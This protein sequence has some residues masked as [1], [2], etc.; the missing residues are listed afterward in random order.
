MKTMKY[1]LGVL[2][3]LAGVSAQAQGKFQP[4]TTWPFLY[5]D[6]L[7]GN[8]LNS[9]GNTIEYD[10]LNVNVSNSRLYYI[11]G[12]DVMEADMA[13]IYVARVGSD[14]YLNAMG[15]LMRVLK[16]TE[17]G[18]VLESKEINMDEMQK[19]SIG[20]GKSA[21]ASTQ[22]VSAIALEGMTHSAGNE[23]TINKSLSAFQQEKNSGEDLALRERL[24]L[25]VDG[26]LV[27]ARKNEVFSDTH[28]NRD[29]TFKYLKEKKI[30]WNDV[31]QLADLVEFLHGQL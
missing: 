10:K 23:G 13:T 16:E 25:I 8:V 5:E 22:N 11:K 4:K 6:F 3:L 12:D 19:T 9:K 27:R 14:V 7:A 31:D 24:F 17:H 21:I 15:K 28:F 26:Y 30:K 1:I 2:L 29:E 20:Y 18:A